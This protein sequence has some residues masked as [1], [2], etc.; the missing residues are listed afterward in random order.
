MKEFKYTLAKKGKI[1]CTNCGKKTAVP[2]I[3]TE[4]GNIVE[5][6]MRCDREQQCSYHRK[7]ESN[8]VIFIPKTETKPRETSYISLDVLEKYFLNKSTDNLVYF[9]TKKFGH[10][11]VRAAIDMYF[12][13]DLGNGNT[14]FWQIDQLERVRT[15][16]IMEYNKTTGKRVKDASGRAHI[17]WIHTYLKIESYNLRQ[18]LFG[19]H[20]TKEIRNKTIAIV[21]SEKTA[22]IMSICEPDFLWLATGA[23]NGLKAEYLAPI[24]LRKIIAFPDKGCYN[25][26]PDAN[27]KTVIGWK[28]RALSLND[29]GFDITVNDFLENEQCES[30]DDIAD[31]Y[32]KI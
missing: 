6:A 12:V 1:V 23:F 26:F 5:G 22:F 11:K 25:D 30:G 28:N 29:L 17:N 24:K 4:T 13:C 9:L 21:E 3:E 15:G 20:L 16:K 27:G 8:D 10:E 18:C 2:Y 14:I 31:N 32:L 7:P 19:L